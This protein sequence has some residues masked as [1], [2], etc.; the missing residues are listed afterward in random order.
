MVIIFVD[1]Y[2]GIFHLEELAF[3]SGIRVRKPMLKISSKDDVYRRR[4]LKPPK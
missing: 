3:F 2:Y 1:E 4:G